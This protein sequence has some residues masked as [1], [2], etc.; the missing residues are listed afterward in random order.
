M[1]E[2]LLNGSVTLM[3]GYNSATS[4]LEQISLSTVPA[5]LQFPLWIVQ[6]HT[7]LLQQYQTGRTHRHHRIAVLVTLIGGLEMLGE[8]QPRT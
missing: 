2:H 6:F 8:I 5:S 1:H 7:S 3:W 4:D